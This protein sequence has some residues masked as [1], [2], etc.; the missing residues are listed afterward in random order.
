M[1]CLSTMYCLLVQHY[2][3]QNMTR[4]AKFLNQMAMKILKAR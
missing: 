2:I 1:A 3:V 4:W